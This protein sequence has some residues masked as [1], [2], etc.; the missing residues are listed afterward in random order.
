MG[1]P[2]DA[3][4]KMEKAISLDPDLSG[5]RT[6]LAEILWRTGSNDRAASELGDALRMDPYDA[7]AYDLLGRIMAGRDQAAQSLF[8][9]EKATRLRPGYAPHLYDYALEL[10]SV[11]RLDDAQASARAALRADPDMAEAHEL[12]GGL[13]A[14]RRQLAEAA[15][16]YG[17][18]I[19]LKPE[20][21]RAHLDLA[22][23]LAAGGDMPGAIEQ[24][25]KAAAGSDPQVAQ[26]AA[27]A[28]Q[29]LGK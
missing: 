20:F 29:R 6:G 11:N 14:G 7:S 19:R 15:H 8:A 5:G 2:A 25:R 12:L 16:E 3:I 24:L 13:L 28:L 23:V 10:S 21:A 9:L 18:A 26:L 4:R 1:Q 22:R 17:E 27:Q